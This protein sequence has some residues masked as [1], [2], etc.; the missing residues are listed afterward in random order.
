MARLE[1]SP[2]S[3]AFLLLVG[4][5]LGPVVV[6]IVATSA[7]WLVAPAA[8]A[9]VGGGAVA[10]VRF[11]LRQLREYR[12]AETWRAALPTP[13]AQPPPVPTSTRR[14]RGGRGLCPWDERALPG[15]ADPTSP[16]DPPLADRWTCPDCR[17]EVL[18]PPLFESQ[19][20]RYG[21]AREVILGLAELHPTDRLCPM[22]DRRL[23][24]PPLRDCHPLVCRGCGAAI[25]ADGEL[26]I[27][28]GEA[29]PPKKALPDPVPR[30]EGLLHPRA[31]TGS[32]QFD[33]EPAA[34]DGGDG[35]DGGGDGGDGGGG[36]D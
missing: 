35:G 21:L 20:E 3:A 31:G 4:L 28:R 33:S 1:L 30:W 2:P 34:D 19:L 26:A 9:I 32:F 13:V 36:G 14:P 8:A 6:V 23:A 24:A 11:G 5:M 25:F 27:F 18:A 15:L 29:L 22:C 10:V 16:E 7:P 12:E 17:A